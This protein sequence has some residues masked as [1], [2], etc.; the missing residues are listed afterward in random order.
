MTLKNS[1]RIILIGPMGAGKTSIG[2]SL[3]LVTTSAFV[4]IDEEI[5]KT[6]GMSIPEIF[7]KDGETG[8]RELETEV[9]KKC[10][11]YD[12]AVIATGGGAVMK[13][14]N[15]R[16]IQNGG[17]VVY[18]HA[19]VDVQYQRT[20]KDNNRPM[21][22]VDDR[23]ERLSNI[24][25]VREPI[26]S[27]VCDFKVDSGLNSVHDCVEQIKDRLKEMSWKL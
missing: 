17:F 18:L 6:A 7:S 10:L 1:G 26:Y 22:N 11:S 25:K 12:N 5:V 8:F 20:L 23:R 19:D 21:I 2:K 9:L 4:D 14:E 16:L 3:A 15:R 27:S 13:E 24:F